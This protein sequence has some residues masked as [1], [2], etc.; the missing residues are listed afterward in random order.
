[1]SYL[2]LPLQIF[3]VLFI[4]IMGPAVILAFMIEIG[5]R[6]NPARTFYDWELEGDYE[7]TPDSQRVA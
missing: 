2:T 6:S 7:Y 5:T 1:M 4:L 3:G